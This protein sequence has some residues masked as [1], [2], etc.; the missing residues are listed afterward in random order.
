MFY[1][2]GWRITHDLFSSRTARIHNQALFCIFCLNKVSICHKRCAPA[3]LQPDLRAHF[4]IFSQA[5]LLSEFV[6]ADV[7]KFFH[8]W[9]LTALTFQL[10]FGGTAGTHTLFVLLTSAERMPSVLRGIAR[11]GIQMLSSSLVSRPS[12]SRRTSMNSDLAQTVFWTFYRIC[13]QSFK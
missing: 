7:M 10:T 3:C 13:S 1:K 8:S 6:F 12:H 4:L 11:T 5:A 9:P 2:Y